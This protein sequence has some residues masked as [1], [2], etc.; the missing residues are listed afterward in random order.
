M[1]GDSKDESIEY[2]KDVIEMLKLIKG[3]MFKLDGNKE[4]T[5]AMWGAYMSVFQFR[6]HKL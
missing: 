1:R 5:H 6:Q 2:K 3:V 4:L